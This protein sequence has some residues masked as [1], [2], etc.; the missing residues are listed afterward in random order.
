[1]RTNEAER[2][3]SDDIEYSRKKIYVRA[4]KRGNARF[5]SVSDILLK[6]LGRLPRTNNDENVFPK[7]NNNS[8]RSGF[9]KRMKQLA[10]QFN[11]TRFIKIHYHTFRHAF[12]IR[13]YHRTK[14][15]LYVKT[16]LGHKSLLTTQKYVEIYSQIYDS[17]TPDQF[18]SKV[19]VTKEERC[20]LL[21]DGWTFIK[22]DGKE[23]YF[24]K[25][26]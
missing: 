14:D 19:A 4:S 5:I 18:I 13:T 2:L 12:A 1:C 8:R 23:W 16:M 11:N 21:N 25:P 24:R 17:N 7:R 26:K 9:R 10:R 20:T 15:I 22:N 6:M 3:Q